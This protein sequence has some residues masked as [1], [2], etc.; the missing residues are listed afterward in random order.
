M[1]QVAKELG[2]GT[3]SLYRYAAAKDELLVL[4]SDAALGPPPTIAPGTPWRDGLTAWAS[5]VRGAYRRSPWALKVP[6]VGPP[7]GPND[8]AWL[9]VGWRA[10]RRRR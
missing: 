7:L 4:M 8:L 1:A 9:E 5:G 6:I 3:M 2:V 10:W